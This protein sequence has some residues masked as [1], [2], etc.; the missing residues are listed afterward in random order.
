MFSRYIRIPALI[1]VSVVLASC[2]GAS[3]EEEPDDGGAEYPSAISM[4]DDTSAE[5][6][7]RFANHQPPSSFDPSRST[8]GLD[9]TYLTPIYDRLVRMMPDGSIEPMLAESFDASEEDMTI[10]FQLRDDV[11]FHDGTM[12]DAD[13]VKLNIDRMRDESA[14]VSNEVATIDEVVVVDSSTVEMKLNS[15]LASTLAVL[16]GRAGMIV[17]GDAIESDDINTNPVGA[18]PYKATS[19]TPGE[20]ISAERFDNYWNKDNEDEQNV[21]AFEIIGVQEGQTRLNGLNSGEYDGAVIDSQ[22][23]Q[24][25]GDEVEVLMGPTPAFYHMSLNSEE[26][27]I[28]DP[29]IA[30]AINHAIDREA[31]S[32][33]LTDGTCIPQVTPW[34]NTSIAYNEELGSGLDRFPYDPDRAIEL[35]EEAGYEDPANGLDSPHANITASTQMAEV[36]QAQLA[37]VGI[38]I[39]PRGQ[40]VGGVFE[41][42]VISERMPVTVTGYTGGS[43]PDAVYER[44]LSPTAP[45]NP[46]GWEDEEFSALAEDGANSI[47]PDARGEA[48]HQMAEMMVTDTITPLI[49]ICNTQRITGYSSSASNVQV[50]GDYEEIRYAAKSE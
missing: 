25:A 22:S 38:T 33:G 20:R 39:N 3:Q 34:S 8:G 48:Y 5:A 31:I 11:E 27:A 23:A 28:Q 43:D 29:R 15:G 21:A 16:S 7:F 14:T 13:V 12:L 19:V 9:Q 50:Y 32:E 26:G 45:Y 47:D 10:T 4:A 42:F 44:M 24:A 40:A 30:E 6:T 41:E 17:S 46:G 49:T 36:V 1:T 35:L 2:G 18:G 37:E